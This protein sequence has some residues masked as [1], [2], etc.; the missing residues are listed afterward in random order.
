MGQRGCRSTK[1]RVRLHT[2]RGGGAPR[3]L[4]APRGC[5]K[6]T[7]YLSF[8]SF[9]HATVLDRF[10]TRRPL[11]RCAGVRLLGL[12]GTPRRYARWTLPVR[13]EVGSG[14]VESGTVGAARGSSAAR[15]RALTA[16]GVG[17][18]RTTRRA[19]Y[20]SCQA[21]SFDRWDDMSVASG[22]RLGTR[23]GSPHA[24]HPVCLTRR[25]RRP[26][27]LALSRRRS[28]W[29]TGSPGRSRTPSPSKARAAPRSPR[30]RPPRPCRVGGP[31]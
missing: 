13:P 25:V 10:C 1:Q 9:G 15:L 20:G 30:P 4:R 7:S 5:R 6:A 28:A 27:C 31:W 24:R 19:D 16:L 22:L 14:P 23:D 18:F 8:G 26:G 3:G 29:R 21:V 12:T 2:V 11:R 17:C